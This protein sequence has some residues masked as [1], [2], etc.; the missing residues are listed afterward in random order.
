MGFDVDLGSFFL[1]LTM[2]A[3]AVMLYFSE[4]FRNGE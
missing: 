3:T 1:G 2:G 4:Y